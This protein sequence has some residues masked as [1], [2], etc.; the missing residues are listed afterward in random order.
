V[1]ALPRR[2]H[3]LDLREG[4]DEIWSRRFTKNAR[5]DVRR[6]LR[7]GLRVE[8]DDEGRLLDVF[9]DLFMRSV[10]RWA[11]RQHEPVA[12]A[13]WRAAQRDSR[14]KLATIMRGMGSASRLWV[15]WSGSKPAAAMLVLQGA[16]AHDTRGVMDVDIARPTRANHLL[17]QL[18]I[19]DACRAGCLS[20]HM[21]ETGSNASLAHYKEAFGARPYEYA[22]YLSEALPLSRIDNRART[23]VKRA[24]RFKDDG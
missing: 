6:A 12:L 24:L 3:I 13:R 5:T 22:E 17:Q 8:V 16:N 23:A 14:D 2:A 20:Y 19:E 18:A 1:V 15:A 21:G 7:S 10:A 11:S 4:Y 9:W